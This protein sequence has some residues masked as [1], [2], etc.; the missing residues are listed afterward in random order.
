MIAVW[1]AARPWHG[2]AVPETLT[3][4]RTR[5]ALKQSDSVLVV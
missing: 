1:I 3:Q 2:V 5:L 4:T